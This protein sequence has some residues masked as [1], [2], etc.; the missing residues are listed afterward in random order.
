MED[1]TVM[2]TKGHFDTEAYPHEKHRSSLVPNDDGAV[3]GEVFITGNSLYARLQRLVNRFG[4][5]AR[6]IEPVPEAER[7]DSNVFKVGTMVS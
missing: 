7:V 3:P 1:K 2:E 6:G 5:E 4:V